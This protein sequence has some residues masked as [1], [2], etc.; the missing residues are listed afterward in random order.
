MPPSSRTP[1]FRPN[2]SSGTGN[3]REK[4]LKAFDHYYRKLLLT[5]H[6]CAGKGLYSSYTYSKRKCPRSPKQMVESLAAQGRDIYLINALE[7]MSLSYARR[8]TQT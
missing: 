6:S 7:I 5:S 4:L 2:S 1:Q 8:E 3:I